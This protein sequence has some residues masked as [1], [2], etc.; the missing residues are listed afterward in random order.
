MPKSRKR[1]PRR[2]RPAATPRRR[3]ATVRPG[4]DISHILTDEDHRLMRAH[5]DAAARGDARAAYEHLVAGAML[6]GAITPYLL[7][8]LVLLGGEAPGWMYSR[9]CADQAYRWMLL[10]EDRRID[11][12]VRQ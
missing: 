2:T 7:R 11:T 1:K 8:E 12:A 4:Q 9:W 6:E 3:V 5:L 10:E